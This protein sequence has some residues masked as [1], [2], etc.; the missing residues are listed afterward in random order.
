MI[1]RELR[2]FLEFYNKK[3]RKSFEKIKYM[4]SL[5][6]KMIDKSKTIY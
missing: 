4:T 3:L 2:I 6:E 1:I 5:A